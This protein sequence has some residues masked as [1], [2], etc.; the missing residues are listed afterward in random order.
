MTGTPR[1]ERHRFDDTGPETHQA[2][3]RRLDHVLGVLGIAVVA[4]LILGAVWL[5]R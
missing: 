5:L 3:E 4:T 1:R 2:A